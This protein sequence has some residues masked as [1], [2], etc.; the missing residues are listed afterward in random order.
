MD[1][2]TPSKNARLPALVRIAIFL[3]L[4]GP[5]LVLPLLFFPFDILGWTLILV[6]G[7]VAIALAYFTLTLV[8]STVKSPRGDLITLTEG[9]L[10]VLLSIFLLAADYFWVSVV[11]VELLAAS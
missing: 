2:S 10:C 1:K 4:L 7:L 5:I 8:F 9:I 11:W 3:Y 6:V